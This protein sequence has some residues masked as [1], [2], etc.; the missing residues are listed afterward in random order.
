[1]TLRSRLAPWLN[2][3][4]LAGLAG[5]VVAAWLGGPLPWMMGAMV[6]LAAWCLSGGPGT[7][8][9]YG[10]EAGQLIVATALGLHFT[11]A[12]AAAAASHVGPLLA[13]SVLAL[14]LSGL[15]A[16]MLQR[17]GGCDRTTAW[18]ASV[19]GGASEM[20]I[21]A[22]RAGARV[23]RV[24][25]AQALR[26]CGVVVLVPLALAAWLPGAT[27]LMTPTATNPPALNVPLL[28]PWH[29][30]GVGAVAVLAAG[31]WRALR[32][33]TPWFLGPLMAVGV[34]AATGV[35]D[36]GNLPRPLVLAGQC[37]LGL[38]LG[39]RLERQFLQ[40][41][42]RFLA[43]VAAGLLLLLGLSAIVAL[44]LSA[45]SGLPFADMVLASAPGGMA[46][47][48]ATAEAMGLGVAFI[49]AS[50]V[51]RLVIVLGVASLIRHRSA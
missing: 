30:L 24:A 19:P 15:S 12:I 9:R 39:A 27:A 13:A 37:L 1:M 45:L 38:A 34:L 16:A 22:E 29:V 42:P 49:T 17:W 41:A 25:A 26:V 23:D 8:P 50:H 10:R 4:V 36:A 20:S 48:C 28:T 11:P 33:P 32:W 6:G 7:A 31:A 43:L 3:A 51:L 47:M 18:L 46:E 2:P 35:I 5:A 14:L 21:M 40:E 44:G